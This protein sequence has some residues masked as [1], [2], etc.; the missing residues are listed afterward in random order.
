MLKLL[1]CIFV[2][3]KHV[4]SL[5]ALTYYLSSLMNLKSSLPPSIL[6]RFSGIFLKCQSFGVYAIMSKDL[7]D[8]DDSAR[9][10]M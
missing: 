3:G 7:E 2:I 8:G 9:D 6:E 1:Y 4:H 5:A 10:I